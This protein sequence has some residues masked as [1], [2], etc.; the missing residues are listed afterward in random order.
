M[1]A[2]S[3]LTWLRSVFFRPNYGTT[4]TEIGCHEP[5]VSMKGEQIMSNF[6]TIIKAGSTKE[7]IFVNTPISVREALEAAGVNPNGFGITV[8]GTPATLETM[9]GAGGTVELA[10]RRN[11]VKVVR[12]NQ[13]AVEIFVED[14][15]TVEDALEVAGIDSFSFEVRL[16]GALADETNPVSDGDVISLAEANL[17]VKVAKLGSRVVELTVASGT[18]VAQALAALQMSNEGFETRVNGMPAHD[19]TFLRDNDIVTLIPKIK[20]G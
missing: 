20:G 17:T 4:Q 18:T 5:Q 7:E 6:I 14:D 3:F 2:K 11:L 12:L 8:N 19:G 15:A 16:N 13:P 10:P 9:V 1:R